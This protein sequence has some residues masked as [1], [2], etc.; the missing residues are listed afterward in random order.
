MFSFDHGS[1]LLLFLQ[2]SNTT[3]LMF[4][5][6]LSFRKIYVILNGPIC[7]LFLNPKKSS[8]ITVMETWITLLLISKTWVLKFL[9]AHYSSGNI[10]DL[11]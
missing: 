11:W 8:K 10:W 5:F 3:A 1:R 4:S 2:H 6:D 9:T 7:L